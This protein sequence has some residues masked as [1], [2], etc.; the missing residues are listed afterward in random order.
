M[1]A[2]SWGAPVAVLVTRGTV[3]EAVH[4][5]H[6]A[7][8]DGAGRLVAAAG[9]PRRVAFL[10]SAAKPIQALPLVATG[11]ADAF[12]LEP[13]ELAVATGSHVAARE[14]VEAVR[15]LLAKA[16]LDEGAL[17][18]GPEVP[19]DPDVAA[20]LARAGRAAAPVHHNC[21]GKHAGML[22][23]A[24]HQGWPLAYL[25]AEHP[26]QSLVRRLV[27]RLTG[28]APVLAADGC[29]VPTFAVTL[30][31]MARAYARLASGWGLEPELAA[32]ARRLAEAMA[33]APRLVSGEG[34]PNTLLLARQGARWLTKGGAE[35]VWC[36]G[37][38]ASGGPGLGVAA[39]VEDGAGR[40]AVPALLAVLRALG[41]PGAEDPGL[42]PL[43]RPEL[44]NS[45]GEV[46]GAVE[47]VVP[48]GSLRG[49]R[50]A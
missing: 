36:L 15:R 48:E 2:V 40:A 32:A 10:R 33:A 20:E 18:C 9:E 4:R 44:H 12:G 28:E 43:A 46:V 34:T 21:S 41:V 50:P 47:A 26:L 29:G 1:G 39:K 13:E 11:A 14:H 38:R 23:T 35:G 24:R 45:R 19:R 7:V 22:A 31:G 5:V 8:V 30:A 16:G 3:V 17:R 42:E 27:Q 49:A 6:V 25:D 37:L